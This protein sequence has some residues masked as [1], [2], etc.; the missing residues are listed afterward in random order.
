MSR[1][2]VES[3]HPFFGAR[4]QV[5][6]P[7][8]ER[9]DFA[10]GDGTALCMH[11]TSGG[12]RGPVVVTPGTAMTALSYCIDTVPVNFVEYL[13]AEGYDVWLLDWR[14][15]PL[16]AVHEA[17]YTLDEVARYDWPAAVD[18]VLRRTGKKQVSVV[19]HCLSAP[20]FLFS[21]LRNYLSA[22]KI[23]VCVASQV[24]LHFRMTTIGRI[25][26]QARVDRLLPGGDMVHQQPARLSGQLSDH[27]ISLLAMILPRSYRC[28]NAVCPR[29]SATFGNV[30]EH[31][32]LNPPTHAIMGE[33]IPECVTGF[34]KDVAIRARR[35]CA[36][37]ED[38][39]PQL[40]R[41][42]L[43]IHLLS[44]DRNEMF[45]PEAT[46]LS[47]EMLRAANRPSLYRRSVFKGYGHLDCFIGEAAVSEVWPEILL[48]LAQAESQ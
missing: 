35:K 21:V 41:L 19:A 24:A 17:P 25:K 10:G 20:C 14:T 22:E 2:L 9:I 43:P 13:V 32:K 38:D 42:E 6:F 30:I 37:E 11:H 34:L 47:Y 44:G 8:L 48:S 18:E 36:L 12:S 1:N 15:S 7:A 29:H 31:S 45:V 28:D 46:E 26:M 23:K 39:F 16:L 27:A 40:K 4:R 5:N 33:L 3:Y